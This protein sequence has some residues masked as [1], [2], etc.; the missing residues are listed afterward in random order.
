MGGDGIPG[1]GVLGVWY[2]GVYQRCNIYIGFYVTC[3]ADI[4]YQKDMVIL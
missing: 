4:I 2:G 3:Q 1:C